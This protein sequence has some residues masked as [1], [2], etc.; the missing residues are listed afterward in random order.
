MWA[1][2]ARSVGGDAA[3]LA[4]RAG[5]E[6][7]SRDSPSA[8]RSGGSVGE[9]G[10]DASSNSLDSKKRSGRGEV[11]DTAAGQGDGCANNGLGVRGL[12]LG[13]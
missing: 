10:F 1:A 7:A 5:P 8:A 3:G 13:L 6:R 12:L 9:A 11:D 2:A 4:S